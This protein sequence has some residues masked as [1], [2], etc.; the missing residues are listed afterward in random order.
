MTAVYTGMR[1]GEL[2]RLE[3]RD[4]DF[5]RRFIT[6]RDTKNHETRHVPINQRLV[7]MLE[8]HRQKQTEQVGGIVRLL[9]QN[10]WTGNP[11]VDVRGSFNTAL[12]KA[13]ITRHFKFHGLRH[14]AASHMVM[15]G[16]DLRTVGKILGHKTA[17]ITLRYAHLAPDY[18]KGAV[19]RLNFSIEKTDNGET[20][21]GKQ[22]C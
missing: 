15:A 14:A 22:S 5:V 17:Q 13:K 21:D 19:D 20:H 3:W 7:E 9:F 18:L 8:A 11:Y 1:F 16:V 12:E 10:Q 6:V 2:T 4:V